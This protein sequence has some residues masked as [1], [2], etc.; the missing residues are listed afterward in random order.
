MADCG[1]CSGTGVMYNPKA[2]P[3]QVCN[4]SGKSRST[5]PH[6]AEQHFA[7]ATSGQW[8]PYII[9]HALHTNV[10]AVATTRIEGKWTAYI[11][12]VPGHHHDVEKHGVLRHGEKLAEE[13]AVV[14][15]P[16]FKGIPYAH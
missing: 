15:F 12:N 4:G 13:I 16:D 14:L 11:S 7:D 10:L 6:W 9:H 1:T 2:T 5:I 3:C 8:H